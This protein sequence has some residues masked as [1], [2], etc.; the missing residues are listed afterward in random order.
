MEPIGHV[1]AAVLG[2]ALLTHG[3]FA[4]QHMTY[5][6]S[7]TL[8]PQNQSDLRDFHGDEYLALNYTPTV[9]V[10]TGVS[11]TFA[12]DDGAGATVDAVITGVSAPTRYTGE[13]NVG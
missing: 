8:G 9:G 1:D 7:A 11:G 13:Q 5:S 3:P 4:G 10:V 6:G 2:E 12:F